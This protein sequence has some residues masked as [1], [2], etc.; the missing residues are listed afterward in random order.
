MKFVFCENLKPS[1]KLNQ[2]GKEKHRKALALKGRCHEILVLFVSTSF[3]RSM[4][5][6][7]KCFRIFLYLRK[8]VVWRKGGVERGRGGRSAEGWEGEREE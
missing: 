4:I 3:P 1:L 6:I 5:F 2:C 7:I 8:G